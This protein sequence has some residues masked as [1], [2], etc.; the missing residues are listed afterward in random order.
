MDWD[1]VEW[2]VCG[3]RRWLRRRRVWERARGVLSW[4]AI[5]CFFGWNFRVAS[6]KEG[7]CSYS[8]E[9]GV[10]VSVLMAEERENGGERKWGKWKW[11]GRRKIDC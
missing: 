8:L 10:E 1:Y 2:L 7:N 6:E 9:K 5:H 11:R 4:P 3:C